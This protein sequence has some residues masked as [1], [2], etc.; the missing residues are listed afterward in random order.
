M[1]SEAAL[2]LDLGERRPAREGAPLLERHLELLALTDPELE[3]V[4]D[5]LAVG[6]QT[7][8]R[9]PDLGVPGVD[10]VEQPL[11]RDPGARIAGDLGIPLDQRHQ[12]DPDQPGPGPL[13]LAVGH[14]EQ[15]VAPDVVEAEVVQGLQDRQE[16][17]AVARQLRVRGPQDERL[18]ALV[19]AIVEERRGLGIG[20]GDDDARDPHDV[21]LEARGVEPPVL[22]VLADQD[23]AAL[24]AALLGAGLLVLDVVARD[25]DLDEATDQVPDVRVTAVTRV[26]VRDD[27]RAEVDLRRRSTL[28]LVHLG[29]GEVLVLVGGQERPDQAGRLIGDLA[30][31]VAREVGTGILGHRTLRRGGPAAEVDGLDPQ[32]LHHHGLTR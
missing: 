16:A 8:F 5:R 30:E 2:S 7:R 24:V 23:L 15:E 3:D 14:C 12:P 28:L 11:D 32:P 17:D 31:R 18:V 25:S 1:S 6:L 20:P 22:L 21:E 13:Q 4:R 9:L 10:R 26:G 19:G 29:A 27:E